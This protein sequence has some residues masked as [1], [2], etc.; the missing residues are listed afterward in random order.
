MPA[1]M[2]QTGVE[3]A[4][5][6]VGLYLAIGLVFAALFVFMGVGRIDRSAVEPTLGF[7]LL[8]LPGVMAFW[9]LLA[10]RWLRKSPP[11]EESNAH[12][13]ASLRGVGS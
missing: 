1:A 10:R 3:L 6:A 9:P 13:D 2:L 11:P 5:T 12:R 4:L 7:R 8:I